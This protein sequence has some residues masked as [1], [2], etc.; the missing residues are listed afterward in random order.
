MKLLHRN[1]IE[2]MK[3]KRELT[4]IFL[5]IIIYTSIGTLKKKK[6]VKNSILRA[7]RCK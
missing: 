6:S 5:K 7:K 3:G 2:P 4:Y 1:D